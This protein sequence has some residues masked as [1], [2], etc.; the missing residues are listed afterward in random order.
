MMK[1]CELK[2]GWNLKENRKGRLARLLRG[3]Q[4]IS[5]ESP[6]AL[7]VRHQLCHEGQKQGELI[8]RI[9]LSLW[10]GSQMLMTRIPQV[11]VKSA[12]VLAALLKPPSLFAEFRKHHEAVHGHLL[13]A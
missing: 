10:G 2:I 11:D 3:S 8:F 4:G 7:R 9:F 6:F 5:L 12:V 13:P 1:E